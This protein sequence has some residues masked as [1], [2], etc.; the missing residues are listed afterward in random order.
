MFQFLL[1]SRTVELKL[2]YPVAGRRAD[3]P[4][5]AWDRTVLGSHSLAVGLV[6]TNIEIVSREQ[7]YATSFT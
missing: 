5:F 7:P 2:Y 4:R 1:Q 3:V 6:F